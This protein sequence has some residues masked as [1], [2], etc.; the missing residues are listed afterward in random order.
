MLQ[1]SIESCNNDSIS[2]NILYD[3]LRYD[4]FSIAKHDSKN[5]N[6]VKLKNLRSYVEKF[7]EMNNLLLFTNKD[8]TK[9]LYLLYST[10]DALVKFNDNHLKL[11]YQDFRAK[12][13]FPNIIY[14]LVRI[15]P[16][17]RAFL[18][19]V[20]NKVYNEINAR[21]KG[22][23]VAHTG[24]LYLDE[25][26]IKADILYHYLGN[27]FQKFN[28]LSINNLNAF[29][30][31]NIRNV[32]YFYFKNRQQSMA[33]MLN[34]G[35]MH[36]FLDNHFTSSTRLNIYKESLYKLQVK[37]MYKRSPTIN[38]VCYNFG[39]FKNIIVPNEFQATYFST[40]KDV[41]VLNN[42]EYKLMKFYDDDILEKEL[43]YHL[44]K[45]PIIYQLLKCVHVHSTSKPYN[46]MLIKPQLVQ[47]AVVDELLT[48]F[49][50]LFNESVIYE[51]IEKIA[52]NFTQNILSGE[53]INLLTL[54]TVK[55][56]HLSF[57]FQLRKF[58]SLCL[59]AR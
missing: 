44:K 16:N 47:A 41:S 38:Q 13:L 5:T 7:Y 30:H 51:I 43:V 25:D 27:G 55:I 4:L 26:V 28:P 52:F 21:N 32:F 3:I 36:N 2:Y 50:T 53:Y 49:K 57:V 54:S 34:F 48:P 20:I 1:I 6:P 24:S 46:E 9:E 17:A 8:L 58:V 31:T 40:Y 56:N 10:A 42:D 12:I 11:S 18:R 19:S 33:T 22:I 35:D 14:L 59:N 37:K 45:L 15:C 29:Y 23:I 39:I